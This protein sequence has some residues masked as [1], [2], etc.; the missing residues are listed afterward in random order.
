[1]ADAG[2]ALWDV[3]DPVHPGVV[4]LPFAASASDYAL[5]ADDRTL[6]VVADPNVV[7]R[8]LTDR[9]RLRQL[10]GPINADKPSQ[11]DAGPLD[12]C[13]GRSRCG[14]LLAGHRVVAGV[15]AD[16]ERVAAR[17]IRPH[18]RLSPSWPGM[19]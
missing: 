7:L 19:L 5:S 8:D 2:F 1:V 6:A 9:T 11:H 12:R 17:S 10:G 4:G 14:N 18:L 3:T 13:P 16:A 15:H